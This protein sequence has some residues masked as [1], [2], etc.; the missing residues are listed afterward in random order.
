MRSPELPRRA[1]PSWESTAAPV[2]PEG[3]AST[4]AGLDQPRLL[5]LT[6]DAYS[7]APHPRRILWK[8]F[9]PGTGR[10]ADC[11]SGEGRDRGRHTGG[12]YQHVQVLPG[13]FTDRPAGLGGLVGLLSVGLRESQVTGMT[14]PPRTR[15]RR[16]VLLEEC[17]WQ[18]AGLAGHGLACRIVREQRGQFVG[19]PPLR[20]GRDE[21]LGRDVLEGREK[22]AVNDLAA[23]GLWR[24]RR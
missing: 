6:S 12:V 21:A 11:V 9:S 10:L 7:G 13:Q 18:R 14:R 4:P 15:H 23:P 22:T 1:R 8:H 2:S 17:E 16:Q 3:G 5:G 19:W 24:G 20:P